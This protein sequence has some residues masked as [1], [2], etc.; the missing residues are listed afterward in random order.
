MLDWP[1]VRVPARVILAVMSNANGNT[2]SHARRVPS[3]DGLRAC[4]VALVIFDHLCVSGS[5]PLHQTWIDF[6]NLG[7]RIF[8]VISGF[9]ITRLLLEE[10]RSSG[11]ISLK[12]FYIRRFF[13]IVPIWACFVAV[14]LLLLWRRHSFPSPA[15]LLAL[16]TY[17]VDYFP[18]TAT[19]LQHLWSLSVEEK[20]YL[21]WPLTLLAAGRRRGV[22]IALAVVL[23]V[24]LIRFFG[25]THGSSYE[26]L[27][28]R[29][30]N[31]GDAIAMGCL[32]AFAWDWMESGAAPA[33][34]KL[35]SSPYLALISIAAMFGV[36][37]CGK[38][39]NTYYLAGPTILNLLVA[40]MICGVVANPGTLIGTFLNQPAMQ[41]IGLWSYGIYLWQQPFTLHRKLGIIGIFPV[42]LVALMLVS[43]AG[44][45]LIE[46]RVQD[47]GR[48]IASR[49]NDQSTRV[50]RASGG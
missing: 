14:I 41:A 44:Y 29:F 35:L 43:I 34:R 11:S 4:S 49:R 38:L 17:N 20:F 7:V 9:I 36:A 15:S 1:P 48:R 37:A 3:L 46:K 6:G 33:T 27:L 13:R 32:L 39:G 16:F 28:W 40:T 31:S 47:Y 19:D 8:F 21:L 10:L 25:A 50:A 30:Q 23:V 22:R 42:N 24:P 45:Y 5:L 2:G 18:P 26:E 12:S